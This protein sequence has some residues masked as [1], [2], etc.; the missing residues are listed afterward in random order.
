MNISKALK[1]K[2]RLVGEVARLK[3]ILQRENSRRDDN[4]STVDRDKVHDE[5]LQTVDKLI[6]LKAAIGAA[7]AP[8]SVE[9]ATLAENKAMTSFYSSLPCRE[10]EEKTLIGSNREVLTYQW[11]AFINREKIDAIVVALQKSINDTQDKIDD[12]NARTKVE[13]AE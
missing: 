2:N 3:L 13:W 6:N 7:T 9:L 4:V 11:D 8:I 10:G 1:V 12:F 5:L